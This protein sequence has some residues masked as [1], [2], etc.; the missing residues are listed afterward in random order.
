[1]ATESIEIWVQTGIPDD[2]ELIFNVHVRSA[3][4]YEWEVSH[5]LS[6]FANLD[7]TVQAKVEALRDI[8]FPT[9]TPKATA[10]VAAGK[11]REHLSEIEKCRILLEKWVYGVVSRTELYPPEVVDVVEDFFLLPC[12][13]ID[14]QNE[15]MFRHEGNQP[16]PPRH[17]QGSDVTSS[18]Q[19]STVSPRP[20]S[21]GVDAAEWESVFSGETESVGGTKRPK[22]KRILKGIKRRFEKLTAKPQAS[23]E[24]HAISKDTGVVVEQIQQGKLMK[25]RV[26]RGGLS[27]GGDVEY[28]VYKM[29]TK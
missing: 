3:Q 13:P 24:P 5:P 14:E 26:I 23:A 9:L 21:E 17:Q 22:R 15:E 25:V 6:K 27:K 8:P 12:G 4:G 2:G 7:A 18:E 1:M 20:L 10:G 19:Q 16:S 28:E 11:S 29:K